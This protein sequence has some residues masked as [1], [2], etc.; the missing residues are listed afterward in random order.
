MLHFF[1]LLFYSECNTLY[2]TL[3]LRQVVS[4]LQE[5]REAVYRLN[6]GSHPRPEG[7]VLQVTQ[8]RKYRRL[9]SWV[10]TNLTLE[11]FNVDW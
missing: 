1:V 11:L 3:L 6:G 8:D 9:G 5:F 10:D 2:L 7:K 4:Y